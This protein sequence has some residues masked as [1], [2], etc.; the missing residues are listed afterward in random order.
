MQLT[1][2]GLERER[3]FY[4]GKLRDIEILLQTI[5]GGG[6]DSKGDDDAEATDGPSAEVAELCK[7]VFKVLYAEE[8]QEG[9]GDEEGDQQTEEDEEGEDEDAQEAAA[10]DDNDGDDDGLG[11]EGKEAEA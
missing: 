4:F 9:E 10:A 11:E 2:G 3:D 1:M 6:K 8:E 7:N 5:E